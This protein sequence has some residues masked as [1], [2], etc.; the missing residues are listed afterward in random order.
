MEWHG[1]HYIPTYLHGQLQLNDPVL[2]VLTSADR[3]N[4]RGHLDH[5][6]RYIRSVIT[7]DLC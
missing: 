5:V 4:E 2:V 7:V 1:M 6:D 3:L